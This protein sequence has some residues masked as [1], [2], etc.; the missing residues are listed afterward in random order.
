MFVPDEIY[1]NTTLQSYIFDVKGRQE[2]RESSTLLSTLPL[3]SIALFSICDVSKNEMHP[4][5]PIFSAEDM[6]LTKKGGLDS[7]EGYT[8]E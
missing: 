8:F 5:V 6:V 1:P 3:S 2:S 7:G 4:W